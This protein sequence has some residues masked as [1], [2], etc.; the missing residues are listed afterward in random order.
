MT[1]LFAE[2]AERYWPED[3]DAIEIRER[4]AVELAAFHARRAR[5]LEVSAEKAAAEDTPRARDLAV[6]L[7]LIG[8]DVEAPRA[9]AARLRP[10]RAARGR[11]A[12]GP[13]DRAPRERCGRGRGTELEDPRRGRASARHRIE[14]GPSRPGPGQQPAPEPIR[15]VPSGA[16][17]RHRLE[18]RLDLPGPFAKGPRARDLPRA[19]EWL[20]DLPSMAQAVTSFPNRLIQYP[21][22]KKKPFGRGAALH[23]R[24]YLALHPGGAHAD[25]LASWLG[26]WEG[27]RGN[28]LAGVGRGQGRDPG[29]GGSWRAPGPAHA[30]VVPRRWRVR[31]PDTRR[32]TALDAAPRGARVPRNRR[33]QR[34]RRAGARG[35]AQGHHPAHPDLARLPAREPAGGRAR[36]PGAASGAAGRQDPERRAAPRRRRPGRRP[37]PRVQLRR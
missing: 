35:A 23:A 6:A 9:G 20:I 27:G 19:L 7:L 8:S 28:W 22:M 4:A 17:E 26:G 25:E 36:R 33:G 32:R 18:A 37:R 21:W 2:R 24:R 30:R 34:G 31:R 1:F 11:G 5:T 12:L 29:R 15:G 14:H 13:G 10:R 16:V 3:N